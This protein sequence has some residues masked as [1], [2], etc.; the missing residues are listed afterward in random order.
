MEQLPRV[1][2]VD[3]NKMMAK[4]LKDISALKGFNAKAAYSVEN[5]LALVDVEP[6]D[7]IFSDLHMPNMNG[8]KLFHE[9]RR[10]K[11][12]TLFVLMTAY[13]DEEFVAK[14]L[15]AGILAVIS[16]PVEMDTLLAF[17]SALSHRQTVLVIDDD[18]NSSQSIITLL[19]K[20][21]FAAIIAHNIDEIMKKL[22]PEQIIVLSMELAYYNS[23]ML[24]HQIKTYHQDIPII[25]IKSNKKNEQTKMAYASFDKPLKVDEFFH[26]FKQIR[27]DYLRQILEIH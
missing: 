27:Y 16:K 14:S 19:E 25:T 7:C 26:L 5:A 17:L 24:L 20:A 6:F 10:R 2:F 1:L 23:I 18:F 8:L 12:D 3:D 11:L 9:F 22:Q 15:A 21:G 13:A 4:T